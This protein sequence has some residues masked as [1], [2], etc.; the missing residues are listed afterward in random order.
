LAGGE[1][2]MYEEKY[3]YEQ[4]Y[5]FWDDRPLVPQDK[6]DVICTVVVVLSG[7]I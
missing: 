7:Q 3:F 4:K 6:C 1:K 5:F 2:E